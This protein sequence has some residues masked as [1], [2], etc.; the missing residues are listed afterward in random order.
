[1]W[2]LLDIIIPGKL[3]STFFF[4]TVMQAVTKRIKEGEITIRQLPSIAYSPFSLAVEE[5]ID[6]LCY[7]D[8]I[9]KVS[10]TG[11]KKLREISI[12]TNLE[13]AFE[14]DKQIWELLPRM[15]A[16]SNGKS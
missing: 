3:G 9:K 6:V 1:M 16:I 15:S 4:S 13:H 12:P 10:R 2:I 11:Y 7:L 5:Y 14:L 8:I